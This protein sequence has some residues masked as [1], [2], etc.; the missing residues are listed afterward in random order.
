MSGIFFF[1]IYSALLAYM[2]GQGEVLAALFGGAPFWWSI[3][4]FA[5]GALVL[6]RGLRTVKVIEL[7]MT[8]VVAF[9]VILLAAWAAPD[10]A[11]SHL[12]TSGDWTQMFLP[13]GVILF[14]YYGASAVVVAHTIVGK[15][16]TMYKRVLVIASVIPIILYTLFTVVVVGVTGSATTE[17]AT[18]GLGQ[19][20][21]P[22]VLIFGNVFAFAAMATSFLALGTA[23]RETYE[24]DFK[25]NPMAAW[26][27]TIAVPLVVFLLGVRSFIQVIGFTGSLFLSVETVLFVLMYW[28]ARRLGD[29]PAQRLHL[30]AAPLVSAVLLIVFAIASIYSM[31]EF[32]AR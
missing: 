26:A 31:W 17:V 5:V 23:L 25:W 20:L 10:I 6:Y 14:A 2:I 16:Q 32:F 21:G 1:S 8:L 30:R 24:W 27:A 28:R 18:V 15:N 12:V 3:I 4:F 29:V 22:A 11:L 7:V 13:Y 9:V 19:V